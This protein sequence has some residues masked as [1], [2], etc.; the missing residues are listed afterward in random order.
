MIKP[1]EVTKPIRIIDISK[2]LRCDMC[3]KSCAGRHGHQRNVRN[4]VIIGHYI[5]PYACK[6]C[7]VP[8]CADACKKGAVKR[9]AVNG[10]LYLDSD[11]CIGCGLCAKKCPFGSISMIETNEFRETK[12][13]E[14]NIK[15]IPVKCANRCDMCRGY[16]KRGCFANC[17]SGSLNIH[18]PFN[19]VYLSLP[20]LHREKLRDL[21]LNGCWVKE[22]KGP[23]KID[24]QKSGEL[25][26]VSQ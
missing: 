9:D 8:Q 3:E 10:V 20:P 17:P 19:V 24:I 25:V 2:C 5:I 14:G 16:R 21:F 6:Q 23:D 18:I 15:K 13:K 12:D 7:E 22:E 11:L 4:G 1:E 26:G